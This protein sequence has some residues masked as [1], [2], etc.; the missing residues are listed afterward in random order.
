MNKMDVT[1]ISDRGTA[2]LPS[3]N[4]YYPL[5]FLKPCALHIMRNL[6]QNGFQSETLINLYWE[7]VNAPTLCDFESEMQK[8]RKANSGFNFTLNTLK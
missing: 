8:I 6:K 3:L 1:I 5:A 4:I 7:A 2:L